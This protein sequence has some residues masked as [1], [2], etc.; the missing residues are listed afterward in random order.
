[1]RRFRRKLARLLVE[2]P[3]AIAAPVVILAAASPLWQ[4]CVQHAII[5]L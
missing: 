4:I 2:R 5:K 3:F 1:M